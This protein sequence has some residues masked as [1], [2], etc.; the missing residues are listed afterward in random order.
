MIL[1]LDLLMGCL[2]IARQKA[3]GRAELRNLYGR[4]VRPEGNT[5]ALKA[6]EETFEP[7]DV[8]WRGFPVIPGSGLSISRKYEEHDARKRYRDELEEVMELEIPE[9]PGCRCGEV[10]RG[11]VDPTECPLFG[12]GCEPGSPIGPCMV[13]RE[14]SC[15][16]LFRWGRNP[17]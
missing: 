10:L 15:N 8:K 4:V 17:V 11:L 12:K 14:G 2:E 6:M 13:S 1:F 3:E 7:F 16:I 5:A 9:P